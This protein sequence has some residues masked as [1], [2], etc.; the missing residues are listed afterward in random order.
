M[1]LLDEQEPIKFVLAFECP[2]KPEKIVLPHQESKLTLIIFDML[3]VGALDKLQIQICE[4][5][6]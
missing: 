4:L 3:Y 5:C 6:D 2:R 1:C